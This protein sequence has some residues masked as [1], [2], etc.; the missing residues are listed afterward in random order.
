MKRTAI[1]NRA[2]RNLLA[3]NGC[4][5]QERY[6]AAGMAALDDSGIARVVGIGLQ[7]NDADRCH[8]G[9]REISHHMG[10]AAQ[11]NGHDTGDPHKGLPMLQRPAGGK[12]GGD[13]AAIEPDTY[14]LVNGTSLAAFCRNGQRPSAAPAYRDGSTDHPAAAISLVGLSSGAA[15][16]R[17]APLDVSPSRAQ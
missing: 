1:G 14:P 12:N 10:D 5:G 3:G 4:H 15:L 13:H 17:A 11:G 6:N 7:G 8:A 2:G 16:A 9:R